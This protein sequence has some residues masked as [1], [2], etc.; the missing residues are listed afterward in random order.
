M[1]AGVL[2]NALATMVPQVVALLV[3]APVEYATFSLVFVALGLTLSAQLSLVI[4]P[5]LRDG[6]PSHVLPAGPLL[7]ASVFLAVA[8][9]MVPLVLGFVD[10]SGA[11]LTAAGVLAFQLRNGLRLIQVAGNH[12]HRATVS[13]LLV[14]LGFGAGMVLMWD[15]PTWAVVW[16]P[17]TL[18]SLLALLPGLTSLSPRGQSSWDW[19]NQRRRAIAGLWAES[20]ALDVGVALPAL[21]LAELMAAH[22]FAVVRAATSALLPVRLVLAPL[23]SWIALQEP[24]VALGRR[25]V[26]GSLLGGGLIGACIWG[27]LATVDRLAIAP[28]SVLPALTPYAPMIALMAT[29]QFMSNCVYISARASV[30]P[31]VLFKARVLDT[32]IQVVS[33]LGGFAIA[34]LDGAVTGYVVLSVASYALWLMVIRRALAG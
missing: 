25:S 5:W 11:V 12:W 21:A 20:S 9:A 16:V 29:F 13:D 31:R 6:A 3:L 14:L 32:L 4:D 18:G 30:A 15:S 17:L 34:Q 26:L 8:G 22:Q 27:G 24:A 7:W 10:L 23:R 33:V 28:G 1:G 19:F 2:T